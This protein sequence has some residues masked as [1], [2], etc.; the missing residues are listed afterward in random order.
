M[1]LKNL[2]SFEICL[3]LFDFEFKSLHKDNTILLKFTE[4][5]TMNNSED[6]S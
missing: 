6:L 1:F 5:R 3:N 4:Y 2:S